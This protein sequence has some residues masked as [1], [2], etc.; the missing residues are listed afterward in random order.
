MAST[1][2]RSLG[3]ISSHGSSECG[4]Y[5]GQGVLRG[6]FQLP[7]RC[8]FLFPLAE[9]CSQEK[10]F[11]SKLCLGSTSGWQVG[12]SLQKFLALAGLRLE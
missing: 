11:S 9:V 8:L 2:V 3:E 7:V 10:T 6:G 12:S 1:I 5:L 4:A